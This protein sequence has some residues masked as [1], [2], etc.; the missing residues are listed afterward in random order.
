[1]LIDDDR[2]SATGG[3]QQQQQQTLKIS[4]GEGCSLAGI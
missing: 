1:M 3:C 2:L 4:I